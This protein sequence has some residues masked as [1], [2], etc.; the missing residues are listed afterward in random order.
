MLHC[1]LACTFFFFFLTEVCCY[2]Y[3]CSPTL[4]FYL[5]VLLATFK[6][7]SLILRNIICFPFVSIMCVVFFMFP[8]FR[9]LGLQLS[10]NIKNFQTYISTYF[11]L[12]FLLSFGDSKNTYFRLYEVDLQ[13]T[14]TLFIFVTLYSLHVS[15]WIVSVPMTSSLL[16]FL[17]QY[18]IFC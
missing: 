1:L 15:S 7:F 8:V 11:C 10:S 5:F 18:L 14:D 2:P 17:L 13:P 9:S 6:I 16:S 12:L 4:R 3:L